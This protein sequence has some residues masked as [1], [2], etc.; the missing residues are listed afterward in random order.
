MQNGMKAAAGCLVA[1]PLVAMLSDQ[2]RMRA[3]NDDGVGNFGDYGEAEAARQLASIETN[4]GLFQAAGWVALLASL[5]AIPAVV[6][7]WRLAVERAPRWAWAGLVLG[8]GFVVGTVVHL[9]GYYGAAEILAV[10]EDREA[11]AQVMADSAMTPLG[12][13]MF[14]P[15]LVGLAFGFVVQAVALRL[16]GVLPTWSVIS[17]A[18][19][20]VSFLV[21]G[22]HPAV[23]TVWAFA[24]AAGFLPALL[25]SI[26]SGAATGESRRAPLSVGR[27]GA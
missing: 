17:I 22:S 19:G 13:A 2:L 14:L 26:R 8:A 21:L 4:L 5:L 12:L 11:A 3:E 18:V 7:A 10:Q 20:S 24:L 9:A 15:Y 6:A 16:S 25:G 27:V 23:S 1:M